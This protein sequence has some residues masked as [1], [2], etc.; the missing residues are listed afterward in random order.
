MKIYYIA[1]TNLNNQSAYSQHVIKMCDAFLQNN[2]ETILLL[3]LQ[4]KI[5]YKKIY[6]DYSLK[7]KK[8]FIINSILKKNLTNF[9][10]RVLF[11]FKVVN[12]IKRSKG[13]K[14]IITRSLITSFC[15]SLNEI[16]HILEIHSEL[17]SITKFL[18]INLNFI[19]SKYVKKVIFISKALSK[20]F[21]IDKK[22]MFILHDGV[23]TKNFKNKNTKN[24]LKNVIYIGS[25][26][27]GRGIELII[28][29]AKQFRELNFSL[30]GD[31]SNYINTKTDH[32]KNLKFYGFKKYKDVPSL[33][34]KSDILL[35]PYSNYVEIRA[36]GINT[37][38]YCSPLKMFDYLAAGKII[39][40]SKLSGICE[41]L[42]HN[43]NS[44]LV[45]DFNYKSWEKS[46][47]EIINGKYNIKKI[48]ANSYKTAKK[49]TWK[50][51]AKKIIDVMQ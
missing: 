8:K 38:E 45:K 6:K 31:N 22:K 5:S 46:I 1:E 20:K 34:L 32:I 3:P 2:F 17:R 35:M 39:V 47:L 49:F 51:R 42:K 36:K 16:N 29:L 25:F 26:Y 40:S 11:A 33:L 48:Q 37:A 13:S 41:V 24:H 12:I 27:K 50:K 4:K 44:I 14:L 7:G 10:N 19:N 30:Y 18:L 21:K 43:K 28:K 15:L 9:L 23:D